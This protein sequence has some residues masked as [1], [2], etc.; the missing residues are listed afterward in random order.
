MNVTDPFIDQFTFQWQRDVEMV[1]ELGVHVYRFSLS[2]PRILPSG[3]VNHINKPGIRYYSNLID[4]L[5][6]YNIT[7]MVTLYHWDLPQ[8]I[9]ELGGWTNPEIIHY[10][11]D[12]A[13]VAFENFGDRVKVTIVLSIKYFC[14][15]KCLDTLNVNRRY[16]LLGNIV[17]V[18]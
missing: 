2:W 3:F 18:C 4:G 1:R 10:F 16:W 15:I 9:Q 6:K 12:F 11:L 7:P 8:R 13:K 17:M 14:W 5:L